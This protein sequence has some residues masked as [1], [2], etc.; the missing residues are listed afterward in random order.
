[1]RPTLAL[2]AAQAVLLVHLAFVLWVAFGAV[3][4]RERRRLAWWH[5]LSVV[6]GVGIEL[7]PIPCPLTLLENWLEEQAGRVPAR[8]PFVLRLLD[9]LVYPQL[10]GWVLT[11][12]AIVV[13]VVNAW[14]YARRAGRPTKTTQA[15]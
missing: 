11:A 9:Q 8:G 4:T 1:M 3:L 7:L 5:G 15:G 14:I 6:Y 13:G 10:P 12:V 2:V